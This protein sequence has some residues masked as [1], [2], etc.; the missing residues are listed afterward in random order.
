MIRNPEEAQ[1]QGRKYCIYWWELHI[2]NTY[3]RFQPLMQLEV[4][5]AALSSGA[6]FSFPHSTDV[7]NSLHPPLGWHQQPRESAHNWEPWFLLSSLTWG[8]Y[9]NADS[10]VPPA[11]TLNG[12]GCAAGQLGPSGDVEPGEQGSHANS[13]E[14]GGSSFSGSLWQ[15]TFWRKK[16]SDVRNARAELPQQSWRKRWGPSCCASQWHNQGNC[17]QEP[18]RCSDLKEHFTSPLWPQSLDP[19]LWTSWCMTL[20]LPVSCLGLEASLVLLGQMCFTYGCQAS[21]SWPNCSSD[22]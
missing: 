10:L 11:L 3:D 15:K 17:C 19:P 4:L 16:L 18:S 2:L 20:N 6:L 22:K 9:W 5:L 8:A 7:A 12:A 1:G 14:T 21:F 13:S